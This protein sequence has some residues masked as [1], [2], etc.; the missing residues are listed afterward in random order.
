MNKIKPVLRL[1]MF[2]IQISYVF[3]F[4]R[5][6]CVYILIINGQYIHW[7]QK[8]VNLITLVVTGGTVSNKGSSIW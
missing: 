3:I 2:E 8:V 7:K 6:L 1:F 5:H 4:Q